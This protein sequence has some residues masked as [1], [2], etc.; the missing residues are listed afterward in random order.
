[1]GIL[2]GARARKNAALLSVG[3][4]IAIISAGCSAKPVA[5]VNG[6]ALTDKEFSRLCETARQVRPQMG[7][8]GYQVLIQWIQNTVMEQEAKKQGVYPSQQDLEGRVDAYRRRAAFLGMDFQQ[9]LKSQGLTLDDFKRDLLVGITQDNV[10][11]KGVTI[12]QDELKKEFEKQ[13]HLYSVPEQIE[14]SQITVDSAEALK[15][16]QADLASN[17]NFGL[18]AS[19]RSKDQFAQSMGRIPGPLPRQVGQGGPVAQPVVDAAYKLN[20]GQ[21]TTPIKVGATWVIAR[22]EKKTAKKEPRFEDVS[23]LLERQLREQRAREAGKIGENQR[24]MMAAYQQASVA[25]NRPEYQIIQE[26]LKAGPG[27]GAPGGPGAPIPAGA[28]GE[29]APPAPPGG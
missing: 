17:T 20:E 16:A 1:M 6:T 11:Y 29:G 21:T 13:K 22:V 27:A 19:T 12:P 2:S 25:I 28:G 10:L 14:I 7:T 8:V 4:G 3:L 26:Q 23:D 9:G 15:Q 5:T 24:A 18:V